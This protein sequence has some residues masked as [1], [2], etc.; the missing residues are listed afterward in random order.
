MYTLEQAKQVQ[1]LTN[2]QTKLLQDFENSANRFGRPQR[3]FKATTPNQ[4]KNELNQIIAAN[5][6]R[7]AKAQELNEQKKQ[8]TD[9][10]K[11]MI[12]GDKDNGIKPII[13]P[14]DMFQRLQAMQ[15]EIQREQQEKKLTELIA[16]TGLTEQQVITI[17][18]NKH[19]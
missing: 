12:Q 8:C 16:Q 19:Q 11:L 4:L 6:Q 15:Q 9:L 18:Q 17:L 13:T 14:S 5:N 1:G 10:L 7:K 2:E 3:E